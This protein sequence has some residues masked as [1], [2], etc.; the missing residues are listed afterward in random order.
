MSVN[1]CDEKGAKR[2]KQTKQ[3]PQTLR[4]Y[5]IFYF[6]QFLV[7]KGRHILGLDVVQSKQ[8]TYVAQNPER[9]V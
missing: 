2:S 1:M 5:Y 7:L 6:A 8:S 4:F 3:I 9:V